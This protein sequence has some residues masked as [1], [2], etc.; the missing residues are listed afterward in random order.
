MSIITLTTDLGLKD[1]YVASVKGS[2]LSQNK[3]VSIVDISHEVPPFNIAEASFTLTNAFK[4]FPKGTVHIIGINPSKMDRVKH[5]ACE[6]EGQYFIGADNGI[7]S[8][9]FKGKPDKI[10]VIEDDTSSFDPNFEIRDI[11]TKA[12]VHLASGGE[13]EE[14]GERGLILTESFQLNPVIDKQAI[15]GHVIH[16]DSY[17]NAITNI[18]RKMFEETIDDRQF[19]IILKPGY[20]TRNIFSRYNDVPVG[21]MVALFG[22]NDLLEIGINQYNHEHN[23]GAATLMGLGVKDVIRIEFA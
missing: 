3:N 21:E 16:I 17:E 4:F 13:I 19:E 12:A 22:T 5:L 18:S 14:L 9:L 15:K 1:Y 7:F 11:F 6:Y 8:L 10:R 2:I 20:S 23:G